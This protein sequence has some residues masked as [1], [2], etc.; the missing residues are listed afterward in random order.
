MPMRSSFQ[1]SAPAG[2]EVSFVRLNTDV[3]RKWSW[4]REAALPVA[5]E[6]WL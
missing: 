4:D 1:R 6:V 2:K 5:G 3:L